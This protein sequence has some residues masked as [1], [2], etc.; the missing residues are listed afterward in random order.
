MANQHCVAWTTSSVYTNII[1]FKQ[2]YGGVSSNIDG[3]LFWPLWKPPFFSF[4]EIINTNFFSFP[5]KKKWVEPDHFS[6][7]YNIQKTVHPQLYLGILL[8]FM[9]GE[10]CSN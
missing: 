10:E 7:N 3:Q 2:L 1:C 8:S 5:N 9:G 6:L 4:I